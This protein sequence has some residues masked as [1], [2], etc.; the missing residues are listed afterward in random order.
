MRFTI[1]IVHR[2]GSNR[3]EALVTTAINVMS[4]HDEIIIVD[5]ASTDQSITHIAKI[6]PKIRI[7]KN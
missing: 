5:N 4:P 1:I 2:N 3:L 7:I 6:F